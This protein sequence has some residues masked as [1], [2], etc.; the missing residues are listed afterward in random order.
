METQAQAEAEPSGPLSL[1]WLGVAGIE[2][3]YQGQ[4]LAIDPFFSRPNLWRILF[5]P[6]KPDEAAIAGKT[7]PYEHILVSHSHYDHL[8]DV[9]AIARATSARI[10]GSPNTCQIVE[11]A[12]IPVS[13]TRVIH[14]GDSFGC[15]D[16]NVEV[17]PA[18][19]VYIPG[20]SSGPLPKRLSPPLRSH[21]Y[22]TD[23]CYSFLIQTG[24]L[25][26]LDWMSVGLDHAVPADVLMV[27]LLGDEAFFKALLQIVRPRLIIPI[28]WDNFFRSAGRPL[29]PIVKPPG[30]SLRALRKMDPQP[31][32]EMIHRLGPDT[33]VLL[34]AIFSYYDL[35]TILRH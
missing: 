32:S 2:L 17:F 10:Y 1:R 11:S 23:A 9:P 21:Q 14:S 34:P 18:R 19:H 5:E 35:E 25:R 4:S 20:F 30:W 6:L 29:K 33:E 8:M 28:H 27:A 13:Q 15:G 31:W 16:F 7:G 3:G 22:R 26:L 24:G 12:G